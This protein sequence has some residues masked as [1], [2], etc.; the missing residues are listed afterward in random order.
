MAV[1]GSAENCFMLYAQQGKSHVDFPH[2]DSLSWCGSSVLTANIIT[3]QQKNKIL[4]A[5]HHIFAIIQ[6]EGFS[7]NK[8]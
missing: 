8:E 6:N 7:I 4:M 1:E 2:A 5:E 3:K